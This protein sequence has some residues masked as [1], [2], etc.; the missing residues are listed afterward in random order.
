M[1]LNIKYITL[2]ILFISLKPIFSI[3]Y[4]L[5]LLRDSNP[6]NLNRNSIKVKLTGFQVG[7]FCLAYE[8]ILN[9][10]YN[11]ELET[12]LFTKKSLMD[13]PSQFFVPNIALKRTGVEFKFTINKFKINKNN[14]TIS[15][16]LQTS[17][18][19]Q[20]AGNTIFWEGG[21]SGRSEYNHYRLSQTKNLFGVFL[22]ASTYKLYKHLSFEHFFVIGCY[23]GFSRTVVYEIDG[24]NTTFPNKIYDPPLY[25]PNGFTT[26][27][28]INLGILIRLNFK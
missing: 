2:F 26:I 22:K 27:P 6:L 18:R 28:V 19:Y 13:E 7:K 16:G 10:N 1:K 25:Q 15:I 23:N 20:H 11:T 21:F 3:N 8:R 5:S 9:S 17:Y 4:D 14:R 12:T 24:R